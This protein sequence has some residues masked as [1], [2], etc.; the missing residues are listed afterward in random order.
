MKAL[1]NLVLVAAVGVAA[2]SFLPT[3]A[4]AIPAPATTTAVD[5]CDE[6][7]ERM[8]TNRFLCNKWYA[9]DDD[10]ACVYFSSGEYILDFI[11]SCL[12]PFWWLEE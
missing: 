6:W 7:R 12:G 5:T 10:P 1:R 8:W 3:P 9:E 2:L 11:D 4:T